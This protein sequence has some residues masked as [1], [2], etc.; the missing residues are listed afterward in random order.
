MDKLR[1]IPLFSG[2][3]DGDA[4]RLAVHCVWRSVAENELIIDYEDDTAE[5]LFVVE[6][7]VRVLLRTAAGREVILDDMT[8]GQYF[9]EMAAIDG[10]PRSANVTAL[11]KTRICA[12]PDAIFREA[13]TSIPAVGLSVLKML[14]GRVRTLNQ[15]LSEYAFLTAKQRLCA[16]L[17]RLS[18]PRMGKDSQRI[19]SPPPLQRELADRISTQREVVTRELA[20]LARKGI[21]EKTRGGLV[22]AEPDKLHAFIAEA[23]S[24]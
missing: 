10:Q 6:G 4:R 23:M 13:C 3:A 7:R 15:R 20:A 1:D 12:M 14:A 5:V 16:E 21:V 11:E 18:R 19:V 17:L 22:I 8:T 2:L 9:G 24:K